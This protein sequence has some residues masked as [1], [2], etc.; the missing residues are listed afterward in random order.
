MCLAKV[1]SKTC[2]KPSMAWQK[3]WTRRR[4]CFGDMG[5]V[6][7]VDEMDAASEA[8]VCGAIEMTG[9]FFGVEGSFGES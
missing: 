9:I 4:T 6:V 8:S 3:T 2:S 5:G 1:V 7:D